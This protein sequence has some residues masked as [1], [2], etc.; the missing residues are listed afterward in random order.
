MPSGTQGTRRGH[1]RGS[2]A[3]GAWRLGAPP[4]GG[5]WWVGRGRGAGRERVGPDHQISQPATPSPCNHTQRQQAAQAPTQR[6]PPTHQRGGPL[7]RGRRQGPPR[8]RRPSAAP[9]TTVAPGGR[10]G[11]RGRKGWGLGQ[12][13]RRRLLPLLSQSMPPRGW[14]A[15][16][17][18]EQHAV[19]LPWDGL[20]AGAPAAAQAGTTRRR[21]PHL[22]QR[23]PGDGAD[24]DVA[25][26]PGQAHQPP[27]NDCRAAA[28][29]SRWRRGG[30]G[31][32]R[33]RRRGGDDGGHRRRRRGR[34]VWRRCRR[35]LCDAKVP[36]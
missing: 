14:P 17:I 30:D 21:P 19:R 31:R 15:L 23:A 9:G 27:P 7:L 8:R 26:P 1:G 5:K 13:R 10:W 34:C 22:L 18:P 33:G 12:S 24:D 25:Q 20:L 6:H 16:S 32:R 3:G 36:R 28:A 29:N 2:W 11:T 4:S 35:L